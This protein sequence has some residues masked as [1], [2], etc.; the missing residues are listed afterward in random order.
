MPVLRLEDFL[1]NNN[2]PPPMSPEANNNA[3]SPVSPDTNDGGF[4][5]SLQ[6]ISQEEMAIY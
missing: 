4:L 5:P 2:A 1:G 3:S 6:E